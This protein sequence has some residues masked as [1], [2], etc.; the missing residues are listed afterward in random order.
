MKNLV[1]TAVV[2]AA[3]LMS[4]AIASAQ[5]ATPLFDKMAASEYGEKAS[6][7]RYQICLLALKTYDYGVKS[8]D[9][10]KADSKQAVRADKA[11]PFIT[12]ALGE[13]TQ[14][15]LLFNRAVADV[16]SEFSFF[17]AADPKAQKTLFKTAKGPNKTCGKPYDTRKLEGYGGLTK[18]A[19]FLTDM[20]SEDAQNCMGV[21]VSGIGADRTA[22][23]QGVIQ[24][25][26]WQDVYKN[27]LRTEGHP[28][29]ELIEPV[30]MKVSKERL[31]EMDSAKAL[32]LYESCPARMKKAKFQADLKKSEPAVIPE[33]DWN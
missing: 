14:T 19:E 10:G 29:D 11:L 33:I 27:A 24:F 26:T 7:E 16:K 25:M 12:H 20:S 21:S 30:G 9:M 31:T 18:A 15:T 28:D 6:L 3:C 8:L 22:L 4:P 17:K 23:M 1:L 13:K 32:E 5:N 2:S